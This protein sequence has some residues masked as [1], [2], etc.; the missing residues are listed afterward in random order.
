MLIHTSCCQRR[1]ALLWVGRASNPDAS[2]A[3]L[4]CWAAAAAYVLAQLCGRG[5]GL[6]LALAF[7]A[8]LSGSCNHRA[9]VKLWKRVL[10]L[11]IGH[12]V[13]T[14]R[15]RDRHVTVTSTLA[16]RVES[17]AAR[18]VSVGSSTTE[19]TEAAAQIGESIESE[20]LVDSWEVGDEG[21]NALV[22][23]W[24]VHG[25]LLHIKKRVYIFQVHFILLLLPPSLPLSPD[26]SRPSSFMRPQETPFPSFSLVLQQGHTQSDPPSF[27]VFPWTPITY[28]D[29][30]V[31]IAVNPIPVVP[32]TEPV[33]APNTFTLLIRTIRRFFAVICTK[34][35]ARSAS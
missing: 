5:C 34:L 3:V 7:A 32:R 17:V 26:L 14:T 35:R 19:A 1:S 10:S 21:S 28:Q 2:W 18:A 12:W 29:S 13:T 8:G 9:Q 6:T 4:G 16:R 25:T 24:D 22:P 23:K 33:Q 27:L 15:R 30:V 11:G 31:P 20:I